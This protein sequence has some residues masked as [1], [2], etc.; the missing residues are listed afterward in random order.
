MLN[1]ET[2]YVVSEKITTPV[3]LQLRIFRSIL[4]LS[5]QVSK[6]GQPVDT[7]IS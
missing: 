4:F 3:R 5:K 6:R 1:F 7:V 2:R